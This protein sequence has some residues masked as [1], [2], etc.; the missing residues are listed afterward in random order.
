[1]VGTVGVVG[2]AGAQPVSYNS[3]HSF[4]STSPS[5]RKFE[6]SVN[7]IGALVGMVGIATTVGIVFPRLRRA[8]VSSG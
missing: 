2:I 8:S 1:M 6:I 7:D 3:R 5:Q 4:S